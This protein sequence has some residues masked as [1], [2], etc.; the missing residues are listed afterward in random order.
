MWRARAEQI[1][2]ASQRFPREK[3]EEGIQLVFRADRDLKSNR[4]DDRVVMEEF[5]LRLTR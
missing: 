4:A 1:H 5:V 3:L 2:A